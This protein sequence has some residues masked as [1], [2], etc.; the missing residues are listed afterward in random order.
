M[1]NL[2]IIYFIISSIFKIYKN[3]KMIF[4][5]G[6]GLTGGLFISAGAYSI[7]N[8]N[9]GAKFDRNI[10]APIRDYRAFLS[11]YNRI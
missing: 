4:K 2:K 5:L 9:F 7:I 3:N 6:F 1:F 8:P 10:L 11:D